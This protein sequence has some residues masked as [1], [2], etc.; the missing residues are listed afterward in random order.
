MIYLWAILVFVGVL[1]GLAA[2][3]DVAV[4]LDECPVSL[5]RQVLPQPVDEEIREFFESLV[6]SEE[7]DEIELKKIKA[8]DYF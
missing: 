2:L 4:I 5:Y 1:V 6:R 3:L 8:M 7:R